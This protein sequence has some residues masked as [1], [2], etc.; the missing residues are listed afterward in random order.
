MVHDFFFLNKYFYLKKLRLQS[1]NSTKGVE[2]G[3]GP[4]SIQKKANWTKLWVTSDS[5]LLFVFFRKKNFLAIQR[6]KKGAKPLLQ[7]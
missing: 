1:P 2:D 7:Q 5:T 4:W 3:N 6:V